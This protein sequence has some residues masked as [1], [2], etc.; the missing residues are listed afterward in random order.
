MDET[1]RAGD[2]R[3]GLDEVPPGGDD[4]APTTDVDELAPP[5]DVAGSDGDDGDEPGFVTDLPEAPPPMSASRRDAIEKWVGLAIAIAC[6]VFVFGSLHPELL[7]QNSTPTGGDMGAHVWGPKFLTDHLLPQFRVTGWTQDWYAGFPAYVFYMVV[8]SLLIVWLSVNPPVWLIPVLLVAIGGVAWFALQRVRAPWAR[9]LVWI[10]VVFAT[11]LVLPIPYNIAFKLVTVSG[12][13]TLPVALYALGRAARVPFPGPPLL[14]AATLPF[15]YDRGFTILGGNGASTMA[16]EFAFSIS[17]TLAFLF[18]ALLFKGIRTRR[19]RALGAVLAALTVLCHLIPGIFMVIATVIILFVRREDRTPWWDA[20]TIG[21]VVAGVLVAITLITIV[22][23]LTLPVLGWNISSPLP[24]WWFPALAS[25]VALALFTGFQPQ[26]ASYFRN[27]DRRLVAIG[28]TLVGTG[29]A[30]LLIALGVLAAGPWLFVLLAI[31]LAIVLFAGWDWRAVRWIVLAG[32]V[33]ALLTG[34]WFVPFLSSSTWMNDMGWEKYTRYADHLLARDITEMS[35]SG[36]PY[37]NVVFALA[38]LGVVLALI[39]RVRF[40]YFLALT[41]MVFAW[42][43]RYFPQYRLWNA[44]LLP[45]LYLAIYLLAG[46]ALALVIR[47][48][49][50]A[51]QDL[52]A[53]RDEPLFVGIAGALVVVA[54]LAVV[55]LGGFRMLPGGQNVTDPADPSTSLYRW[56][57]I[58]FEPSIVQDW[59]AWNYAGLESKPAWGEFEGIVDM[60]SEVADEHG[61]GRAMW[62]YEGD[63]QRFGTP[64]ALMLLPYFTDG[65]VG[66]MEGL[67]FEA[68]STTPFHFLNQSE[69]STAPS[70]A[71]RDLPY[72]A[73][74]I[75]KGVAHLQLMGVKYYMATS[76][77]AITAARGHEDLTEVASETFMAPAGDGSATEHTWAVFEVADA[78]IVQALEFEPVVLSDADDHIDGWVYAAEHPEAVEG[79]PKPPKDPGPAVLWYNDPT[80]WDV[81]LATSGPDDW[82]R[83]ASTDLDPP[84]EPVVPAEVSDVEITSDSVSFSVDE[85]GKPVLV[86]VSYFPNWKVSG[87]EGPYRVS[88][89]FMVVVPTEHDVELYYGRTGTDLLGWF[90]TFLGLVLLGGLVALDER[91]RRRPEPDPDADDPELGGPDPS[92]PDADASAAEDAATDADQEESDPGDADELATDELA[93][94]DPEVVGTASEPSSA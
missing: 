81:P 88:P 15:I 63:L 68:S 53:R 94:D 1:S 52:T 64:M 40:G 51:V 29:V 84:R 42:I 73:F 77:A 67:Y 23:D 89:N 24:Q 74:D 25:L 33:G 4:V 41:V 82:P 18:L 27:P 10:G 85:I 44:R 55:L 43:F 92:T 57:G 70:R 19:D 9:T 60:M 47:S 65:C 32:P 50:V 76:D 7:F 6:G 93:A 62:E 90:M 31:A 39:H 22:P 8:P 46:L 13:V 21:R 83:A 59:A 56:A 45:F 11:V 58:N 66:S 72:S 26:L 34:F 54:A 69:L 28:A 49:V 79:Q 17:L 16:G 61:C 75:D 71:Q 87:A 3:V 14:A 5:G 48:L 30:L 38:G 12:L 91:D 2:E 36:M 78:D 80:R 35:L 20:N 86:K 37:R